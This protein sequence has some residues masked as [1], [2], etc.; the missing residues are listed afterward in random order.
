MGHQSQL[1]AQARHVG[2]Q[3]T[4]TAVA[5]ANAT[6][7]AV[8]ALAVQAEQKLRAMGRVQARAQQRMVHVKKPHA[9]VIPTTVPAAPTA[10]PVSRPAAPPPGAAVA[11]ASPPHPAVRVMPQQQ[12]VSVFKPVNHVRAWPTAVALPTAL[13]VPSTTFVALTCCHHHEYLHKGEVTSSHFVG[14]GHWYL[15]ATAD[16]RNVR[17]RGVPLVS[18]ATIP[19]GS[20][21][22]VS[23]MRMSATLHGQRGETHFRFLSGLYYLDMVTV[24]RSV[25]VTLTGSASRDPVRLFPMTLQTRA[26]RFAGV[27]GLAPAFAQDRALMQAYIRQAVK[28]AAA[29]RARAR[30]Q[31]RDAIAD[32]AEARFDGTLQSIVN[33]AGTSA[34]DLKFSQ[35]YI[36]P[37]TPDYNPQ[38]LDKAGGN[39]GAA[40]YGLTQASNT[41]H[42]FTSRAG[43]VH[44]K[45]DAATAVKEY[46]KAVKN[47]QSA[48]SDLEGNNTAQSSADLKYASDHLSAGDAALQRAKGYLEVHLPPARH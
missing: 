48:I 15:Y 46:Q 47:L 37:T 24:C 3:S 34:D 9:L 8:Q 29:A 6:A 13:S 20:Q 11:A 30:A 26:I 42:D 23:V 44:A 18:I 12:P 40:A 17:Q 36:D 41:L 1:I 14:T 10:V 19:V 31:V 7:V 27:Q 4:S 45:Q 32:R 43:D 28:D 39:L 21:N 2:V 33:Y 22:P 5:S 25:T 35:A 38:Y 16:C